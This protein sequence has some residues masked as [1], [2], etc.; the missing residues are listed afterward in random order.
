[1][2]GE[3][4]DF[5]Q[6]K[7]KVTMEMVLARY[8][9]LDK[10]KRSSKG[11]RGAC[12]IHKGSH[13]NQFHV[14]PKKNRWNCF[15]GC[16][17]EH[18]EGHVI[19]FVAAMEGV[20]LR[21]AGLKIAEWFGL[22]TT[23]PSK[24]ENENEDRGGESAG[25]ETPSEV[26]KP[27]AEVAKES[28]PPAAESHETDEPE[29]KELAFEL[30]K[31]VVDHPYFKQRGI[32]PKTIA[33]FG[34]GFCSR[35]LMKDRI[36]F[37]IHRYDGKLI[38]YTGR[39][40]LEVTD[41]NPKWLLPPNLVKAKVLF[42]FHRVAGKFKT[43]ILVEG[44]LGLVAV[45]QAGFPNVIPLMGR[46]IL[47]DE[48]LSYDQLRLITSNFDQAVLLLDGDLDGWEAT[49]KA[50]NKLADKIFV[51]TIYLPGNKDPLDLEVKQL[52]SFLS[53]LK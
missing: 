16:D 41:D 53:F 28:V 26:M 6:I 9:L 31:L 39:T 2:S 23:H 45:Y 3:W 8:G 34:L 50:V 49:E 29:N 21:E 52:E 20:G 10:L 12:P 27:K 5:K 40:V 32:L 42:N 15:G 35:G 30:K 36:V 22:N 46:D 44:P 51:R 7:E 47:E 33:E 17:M 4:V 11:L 14:D 24:K 37:P 38:G 48:T 43:V 1:M 19:G 25:E 18:L 13:P